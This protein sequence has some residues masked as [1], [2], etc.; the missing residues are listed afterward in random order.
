MY[1]TEFFLF[2]FLIRSVLETDPLA[3]EGFIF[4]LVFGIS[5]KPTLLF[6]LLCYIFLIFPSPCSAMEMGY[7]K[8]PL[9]PSSLSSSVTQVA[10]SRLSDFADV[11]CRCPCFYN[12]SFLFERVC[13]IYI[14]FCKPLL[15]LFPIHTVRLHTCLAPSFAYISITAFFS[16]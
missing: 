10:L 16:L 1:C 9:S 4:R 14:S 6:M 8:A 2:A 11:K 15:S 13:C 12:C 3:L 7:P 5:I